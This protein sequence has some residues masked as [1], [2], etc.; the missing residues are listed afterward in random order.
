VEKYPLLQFSVLLT[1]LPL[2]LKEGAKAA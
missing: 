2:P 1:F